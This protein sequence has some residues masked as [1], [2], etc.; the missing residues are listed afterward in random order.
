MTPDEEIAAGQF[1][2]IRARA[3][4]LA[5]RGEHFGQAA[6]LRR[7]DR[8]LRVGMVDK[9]LPFRPR[10]EHGE[11]EA[12]RA[13][14]RELEAALDAIAL[15]PAVVDA[16]YDATERAVGWT[17]PD[18]EGQA[19]E[20]GRGAAGDGAPGCVRMGAWL[21][22]RSAETRMRRAFAALE[23]AEL[24]GRSPR[25]LEQL[26]ASFEHASNAHAAAEAILRRL[27]ATDGCG[28]GAVGPQDGGRI[29]SPG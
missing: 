8:G 10:Y 20:D 26:A 17:A 4:R 25:E 2:I 11:A 3:L 12:E 24:V 27:D 19:A 6:W 29:A 5:R 16:T 23:A 28:G 14:M 22:W 15:A 1:L 9:V 21:R 13:R 18:A 7:R